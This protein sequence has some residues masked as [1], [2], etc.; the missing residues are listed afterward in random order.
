VFRGTADD[1]GRSGQQIGRREVEMVE[2]AEGAARPRRRLSLVSLMLAVI[3]VGVTLSVPHAGA[4]TGW[5]NFGS[6]SGVG[7]GEFGSPDVWIQ[8]TTK[9]NPVRVRFMV[10][11]KDI[12]THVS[13]DIFCFNNSNFNTRRASGDFNTTPPITKDISNGSWV[14]NFQFCELDVNAYH[15]ENGDV[16]VKLQAKY[17]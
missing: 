14:S 8:S 2:Q 9:Q 6:G 5:Q 15:F 4:V 12:R 10:T 17:P 13:W 3:L 11:G 7:R 16:Q 1:D